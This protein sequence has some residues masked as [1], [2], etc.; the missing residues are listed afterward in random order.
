MNGYNH[1]LCARTQL[2]SHSI[3]SILSSSTGILLLIGTNS[4][5]SRHSHLLQK[6]EHFHC[7]SISMF[8][9]LQDLSNFIL[10]VQEYREL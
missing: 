5:R 6:K 3:S 4:I 7:L 2:L 1:D 9:N 10:I 8:E